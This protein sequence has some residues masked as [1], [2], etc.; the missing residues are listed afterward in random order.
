M[1]RED[2]RGSGKSKA[3]LYALLKPETKDF[4]TDRN[5]A[6]SYH[7]SI[8][9]GYENRILQS[10]LTRCLTKTVLFLPFP[11]VRQHIFPFRCEPFVA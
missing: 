8:R 6:A 4:L 1:G 11:L 2:S 9:A 3:S 5:D 10:D 7:R